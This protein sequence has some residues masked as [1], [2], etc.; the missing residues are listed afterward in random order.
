ML[1]LVSTVFHIYSF[2]GSNHRLK[3]LLHR[4]DRAMIYIFIA[5]AYTPWLHLKTYTDGGCVCIG[6]IKS[7]LYKQYD[8]NMTLI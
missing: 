6:L 7:L 5:G 8:S 3:A 1:F 2:I 4:C